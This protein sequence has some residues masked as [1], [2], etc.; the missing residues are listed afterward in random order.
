[1]IRI[2]LKLGLATLFFSV[3]SFSSF[4][5]QFL[6]RATVTAKSQLLESNKI[7]PNLYSYQGQR[8]RDGRNGRDGRDGKNGA[9]RTIT[10]DG[11]AVNIDLAGTDGEDGERGQDGA[12]ARCYHLPENHESEI[13]L[14]D[15]G[16]GGGIFV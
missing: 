11:S 15:G 10:I 2:Y 9:D 3:P 13:K 6:A 8:G 16:R 4:N 12:N 7:P 1:M 14:A 5:G